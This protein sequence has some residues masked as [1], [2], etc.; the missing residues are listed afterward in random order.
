[1][2]STIVEFRAPAGLST[3]TI[4]LFPYDSDTIANGAGGDSGTE[5]T[6]R[7]GVYQATVT[8]TISGWHTAHVYESGSLIGVYDLYLEDDTS[9]WRTFDGARDFIN[10]LFDLAN[11]VEASLTPREFMKVAAAALFGKSNGLE[12]STAVYRDTNDSKDR[13]T[14]TVDDDGNR[15]AVTLNKT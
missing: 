14:A 12:G 5:A 7:L 6:N 3:P 2:A 9:T 15:S 8:Q 11:G 4:Q 10:A 13:I 1:M